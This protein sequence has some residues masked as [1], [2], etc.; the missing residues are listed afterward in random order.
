M[1]LPQGCLCPSSHGHR[2]VFL[3]ITVDSKHSGHVS[4][5]LFADRAPKSSGEKGFGYKGACFHRIIPGSTCQGGDFTCHNGTGSKSIYG[6][7]FDDKNFI[8]KHTGPGVLSMANVRPYINSSQF[9]ICSAN[10]EWLESKY[11]FFGKVKE[12]M[13]TTKA[14]EC[15]GARNGKTSKMITNYGQM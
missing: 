8:L 11:V 4:F 5:K 6:E 9:F 3:D 12:G 15:F 14:M 1:L 2:I 10:T 13:N 7:K